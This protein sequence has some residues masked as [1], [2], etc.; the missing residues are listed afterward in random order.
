MRYFI[1]SIVACNDFLL[2]IAKITLLGRITQR[3][4]FIA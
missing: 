1:E 4:S 2:T 3:V